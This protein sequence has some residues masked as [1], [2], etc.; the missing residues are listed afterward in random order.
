MHGTRAI[1]RAFEQTSRGQFK[2]HVELAPAREWWI[3][4]HTCSSNQA[5]LNFQ[6]RSLRCFEAIDAC[7]TCRICPASETMPLKASKDQLPLSLH[8]VKTKMSNQSLPGIS[9]EN[10]MHVLCTRSLQ[11]NH[12]HYFHNHVRANISHSCLLLSLTWQLRT[13]ALFYII[14]MPAAGL[15]SSKYHSPW[16]KIWYHAGLYEIFA[17]LRNISPLSPPPR[18]VFRGAVV[19]LSSGPILRGGG[20]KVLRR[21][22]TSCHQTFTMQV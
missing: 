3:Q 9:V 7:W 13:Q 6:L 22:C 14:K 17:L 10:Y 20:G 1:K 2:A 18:F 11:A 5:R 21:R 8:I 12:Y 4:G 16:K 19:C 15:C